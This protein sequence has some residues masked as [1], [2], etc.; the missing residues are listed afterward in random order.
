MISTIKKAL[1]ALLHFGLFV[2]CY[3][4]IGI[5][6]KYFG[7][8]QI[9]LYAAVYFLFGMLYAIWWDLNE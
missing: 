4:V 7:I 2:T 9:E 5:S 1:K 3:S 6:M 8:K